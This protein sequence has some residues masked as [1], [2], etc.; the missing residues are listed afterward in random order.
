M[1][2]T[3]GFGR[4]WRTALAAASVLALMAPAAQAETLGDA[5]VAAYENSGLIEQNRALL[6]A[7]D[8]DV[9]VATSALR[10]IL[11][12]SADA[13]RSFGTSQSSGATAGF[14]NDDMSLGLSASLTL[15][16]F[17]RTRLAIEAAKET[18]LATRETLRRV[19]QD[20]LLRAVSAFLEVRRS[21]EFVAL[22]ENNLRLIAEELRAAE[23]RFEVGEVT[24]TD[25]ALA[26][27]RLAQSRANLAIAEGNLRIARAEYAA[28]IGRAPGNLVPPSALPQIPAQ[29]TAVQ[30]A[31]RMNPSL[32]SVQHQVAA[33]ELN[34][35]R[36]AANM[37]PTVTLRGNYGLTESLDNSDNTRGGSVTLGVGQ[38]I[39]QGGRLSALERQAVHRRDSTRANLL[40]VQRS[41]QQLVTSS[42]ARLEVARASREASERQIRAARVAFRG[43]REEATLGARTTLDVLNAEQELLDAQAANISA[44]IDEY[45]AAYDVLASMGLLTADNLRLD[46]PQYD[47][48]EYF[49]LVQSAPAAR[50]AQGRALQRVL[51]SLGQQ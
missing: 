37:R 33:A 11:D 51:E 28:S 18:V 19:E 44:V 49:N 7:A 35:Q 13:S 27:A 25:V 8:E 6:R 43:V 45:V 5:L 1:G 36:A 31:L 16:D 15:Y 4:A 17:G 2:L 14:A 9:A 12:W 50:S 34:I 39:Y 42:F 20:V 41:V 29:S 22:R 24:R 10:P 38:R 47:P 32:R 30:T 21:I 48:A 26:E 40:E 23:D 46:V 3:T